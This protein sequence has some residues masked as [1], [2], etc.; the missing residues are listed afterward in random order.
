MS[1][2]CLNCRG[3]GRHEAVREIHNIADTNHLNVLFLSETKMSAT[4][5]Q[6]M[7][8]RLGFPN[9]SK[10]SGLIEGLVIM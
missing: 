3:C 1:L 7:C 6:D 9:A 8:R 2:L 10:L 4:G 5:A